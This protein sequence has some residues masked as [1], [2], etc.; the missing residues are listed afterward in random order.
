MGLKRRYR[1]IT[2]N[3]GS[4][5][6]QKVCGK[7]RLIIY[8][9][10]CFLTLAQPDASLLKS[11][12]TIKMPFANVDIGYRA[13]FII[14]PIALGGILF[15]LHILLGEWEKFGLVDYDRQLIYVFNI[16]SSIPRLVTTCTFYLLGPVLLLGFAFKVRF[17]WTTA[18][19]TWLII[20]Y[21]VSTIL[22]LLYLKRRVA[23]RSTIVLACVTLTVVFGAVGATRVMA[24]LVPLQISG[25]DLSK[26]DLRQFDLRGV[27]A[28]GSNLSSSVL[29]GMALSRADFSRSNLQGARLDRS[30]LNEANLRFAN[31]TNASLDWANLSGTSLFGANLSGTS[32]VGANLSGAFLVDVHGLSQDQLTHACGNESTQLSSGLS[33]PRCPR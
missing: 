20:A 12:G 23:Q 30:L 19:W 4:M 11:G 2:H 7:F 3:G 18:A 33:V 32:L 17:L 6:C 26:Q 13:F 29:T 9:F 14:G 5:S 22:L 21:L 27:D 24:L 15:Y 1:T 25:A 31:L 10:F 16:P 8:V 28:S